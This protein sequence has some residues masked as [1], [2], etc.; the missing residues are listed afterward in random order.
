MC[1]S[2]DLVDGLRPKSN[3]P[4]RAHIADEALGDAAL[5]DAPPPRIPDLLR[6][7]RKV[8]PLAVLEHH[9]LE[10]L[11]DAI[12]HDR[13][14]AVALGAVRSP[15]QR[16]APTHLH[17]LVAR[18]VPSRKA[19][20]APPQTQGL[21]MRNHVHEGIAE[22]CP[23]LEVDWVVHEVVRA[24]E[25]LSVQQLEQHVPGIVV[26]QVA[27]HDRSVAPGLWGGGHVHEVLQLGPIA[28]FWK[29]GVPAPGSVATASKGLR[30]GFHSIGGRLQ[31]CGCDLQLLHRL[32][33]RV[34]SN[35]ARNQGRR[36]VGVLR[37]LGARQRLGVMR[38]NDRIASAEYAAPG[39]TQAMH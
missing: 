4:V 8:H 9:W 32:G 17:D 27:E 37:H 19:V 28:H 29:L 35:C 1:A 34:A 26:R 20:E 18:Q 3:Q 22:S 24:Q 39:G 14:V 38:A 12:V 6:R 25:A 5:S 30:L 15:L 33:G 36:G 31:L 16:C 11:W 23:A 21:R 10:V 13:A 2:L 7:Y